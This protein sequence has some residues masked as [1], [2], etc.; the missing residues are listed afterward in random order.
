M[1]PFLSEANAKKLSPAAPP[2][3]RPLLSPSSSFPTCASFS[4][5]NLFTFNIFH[6]N[7]SQGYPTFQTTFPLLSA[8]DSWESEILGSFV[9]RL[10]TKT[11]FY[12]KGVS[13]SSYESQKNKNKTTDEALAVETLFLKKMLLSCLKYTTRRHM[14]WDENGMWHAF[15]QFSVPQQW[16]SYSCC[17]VLCCSQQRVCF[18]PLTNWPVW[19]QWPTIQKVWFSFYSVTVCIDCCWQRIKMGFFFFDDVKLSKKDG[20][21]KMH[22]IDLLVKYESIWRI[23]MTCDFMVMQI[24]RDFGFCFFST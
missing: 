4:N 2:H 14:A 1:F 19:N 21:Q 12:S 18:N 16:G 7:S 24:Y 9:A 20:S 23:S 15:C 11:N 6:S 8:A 13:S 5:F 10:L 17:L 22:S 3:S